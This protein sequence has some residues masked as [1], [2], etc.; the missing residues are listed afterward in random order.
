MDIDEK[1]VPAKEKKD[2]EGTRLFEKNALKRWTKRDQEAPTKG[3]KKANCLELM[4]L[5]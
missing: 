5:C 4:L 3:S 2:E 1:N